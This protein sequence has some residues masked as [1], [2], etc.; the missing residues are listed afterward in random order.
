[1]MKFSM[2]YS[3][4]KKF[5]CTHFLETDDNDD[6]YDDDGEERRNISFNF[7]FIVAF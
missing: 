2:T 4:K 1:M 7:A 5:S 6:D 3:N